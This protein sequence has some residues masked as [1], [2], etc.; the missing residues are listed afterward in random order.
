MK[1]KKTLK[2]KKG[3]LLKPKFM[4]IITLSLALIL[5]LSAIIELSQIKKEILHIMSE[6]AISLIESIA[7]SSDNATLAYSELENQVAERL[8]NNAKIIERLDRKSTL[9]QKELTEIAE[10][11]NLY[12]INIF[13]KK[14]NKIFSSHDTV[15][16]DLEPLHDPRQFIHPLLDGREDAIVIGFK[17]SRFGLGKRYAVAVRRSKGGAVVVNID[18]AEMLRLR[19]EIGVGRLINDMAEKE[20]ILYIVIQDTVGIIAASKN[21]TSMSKISST[22]FL[23]EA[24]KKSIPTTRLTELNGNQIFEAVTPFL[25]DGV[26]VGLVRIGLK[27]DHIAEADTRTK[28]RLALIS[29]ILLVGGVFVFNFIIVNQNYTL[30]DEA[31]LRT[32]TYTGN[33]LANMTDAVVA[34]DRNEKITLFNRAAEG[35]FK[36]KERDA[37]GKKC[38]DLID[39]ETVLEET[40][41]T[42]QSVRDFETE[43]TIFDKRTILAINT[44]ALKSKT[45]E[46]DS[47]VAVIKDLTE[48]RVMEENLRRKEK[49]T[50]MGELA[51]G[52]AHEVRNPL[53]AISMIAQRL[54]KEFE[55]KTDVDEYRSLSKTVVSEV[56][57]INDLIQRFLIFARPPKL[58]L[59]SSDLNEL[60]DEV[61]ELVLPEADS[62]GT[63]VVKKYQIMEKIPLDPN[64]MKQ[65]FLNLVQNSLQAI[66]KDGT[67]S[68]RTAALGN[69][70]VIEIEDT[71]YGI[72]QN[73]LDKI[74]DLYFTTKE[75]G[76]GMGLSIAN[77]IVAAHRGRIE[78][79]SQV[80]VGTIFRVILPHVKE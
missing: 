30:L 5:V 11:N 44:F 12:R 50:A 18:A 1:R 3:L 76:T 2:V 65:V 15:H 22:P 34:I 64:Q 79:E 39:T 24:Q 27:T 28:R 61:V 35:L 54:S 56:S 17:E 14:G 70:V 43:Y 71:G 58:D 45:G 78:V 4:V 55:P 41:R 20:G 32:K 74:F 53:N 75:D 66:S 67:I 47:A 46:L 69:S 49:L 33:I 68:I 48:R 6:E 77:Q 8:M 9:S 80:N 37:F 57:R 16:E 40:L 21:I 13:D 31:Y 25:I 51:S 72:P 59:R 52:V 38:T 36:I 10:Q 60:M 19:K 63:K 23:L 62:K 73:S 42:G 7:V 29:L 26:S